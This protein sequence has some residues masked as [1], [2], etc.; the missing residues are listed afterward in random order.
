MNVRVFKPELT[1]R[2]STVWYGDTAPV[3]PGGYAYNFVSPA[4][5]KHGATL[6]S[7]VTMTGA[8]PDLVLTYAPEAGIADNKIAAK[9]DIP[10]DVTVKIGG[11]NVTDKTGFVHQA[12]SP[13][14]AW[15]APAV[16]GSP[17]FLLHVKTC[18]LT[19]QKT[20]GAA[21]EP[22][23]FNIKRNDAA[24]MTVSITTNGSGSGS[25]TIYELPVGTYTVTEED[26]WSWRYEGSAAGSASLESANW[27]D[28]LACANTRKTT[29]PWFKWLNGYSLTAINRYSPPAGN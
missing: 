26:E 25:T 14:C 16:P 15:T 11:T 8:K 13:A 6:D 10:V 7:G 4:I 22:Y 17:A 24:Y 3:S 1:F 27:S 19:I 18:R 28:T 20:C 9:R 29:S 5:W 2:D 21:N 12:C 23:V